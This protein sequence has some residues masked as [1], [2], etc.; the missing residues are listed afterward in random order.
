MGTEEL[1]STAYSRAFQPGTGLFQNP[2]VVLI[3]IIDACSV[4][5]D[6]SATVVSGVGNSDSDNVRRT[7][8]QGVADRCS[9][10]PG[11][12]VDKLAQG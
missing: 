10:T 5:E 8:K 2:V 11:S 4:N 6:H 7:R 1:R 9:T 3:R 12:S